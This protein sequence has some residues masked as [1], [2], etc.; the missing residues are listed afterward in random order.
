MLVAGCGQIYI[1]ILKQILLRLNKKCYFKKENLF[2]TQIYWKK[3]S[4]STKFLFFFKV[5]SKK[6]FLK[7]LKI[8]KNNIFN[9]KHINSFFKA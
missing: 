9:E 8:K 7:K 2:Q 3:I 4:S 6:F 1:H 5:S